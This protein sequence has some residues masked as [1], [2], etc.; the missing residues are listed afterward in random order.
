MRECA[1]VAERREQDSM[2][3]RRDI[4]SVSWEYYLSSSCQKSDQHVTCRKRVPFVL[5]SRQ[6]L[7]LSSERQL[8]WTNGSLQ[9]K[10]VIARGEH[11][12]IHEEEEEEMETKHLQLAVMSHAPPATVERVSADASARDVEM[13]PATGCAEPSGPSRKTEP[14][15][16]RRVRA[17][18]TR[19]IGSDATGRERDYRSLARYRSDDGKRTALH[20]N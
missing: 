9:A 8:H 7:M 3:A 13:G 11:P 17:R 16:A 12:E 18:R 4:C 5:R 2:E 19:S 6:T 10:S 1:R 14:S 20:R 15:E